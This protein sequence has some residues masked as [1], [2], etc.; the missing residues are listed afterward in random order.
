MADA[1]IEPSL[2]TERRSQIF[3]V[4]S[5]D[6]V[7]RMRSFG[8][9]RSWKDG[10]SLFEAGKPGP[11]MFVVLAGRVMVTRRDG[12][13]HDVTVIE[14]G[15]GEFLAEVGQLSGAPSFVDGRASGPVDA[16]LIPPDRLRA[17][18]V[19]EAELGERVMRALI[20]RRVSLLESHA[21]GPVL[22]ASPDAP[23]LVRLQ[24]FLTRNGYPHTVMN[25]A[26]PEAAAL[27]TCHAAAGKPTPLIL[28]PNGDVLFDPSEAELAG[29]LGMS[30]TWPSDAIFDVVVVGGGPAGLATAVYAASEALSVLVLERRAFGGQAGASAR[31]ENYLGFPTGIS[32]QALAGRA[33]VQAQKFGAVIAVPVVVSS[34]DCAHAKDGG[35][36]ELRTEDGR[37]ARGRAVIV[38][39]G[40]VYRRPRLPELARYE[41]RGVW[42]WAS[43]IEATLCGRQEVVLVGGGNSAGQAAVFL[44][45]TAAKVHV[46]VRG[47]GLAASMSSYL[48]DRIAAQRNIALHFETELVGLSGERALAGVRW[49]HLRSG[50][51]TTLATRNVFLFI[52]ADPTTEWLSRC[53]V[54]LDKAGF[55]RTG[56]DLAEASTDLYRDHAALETSVPGV[57]AIGDVRSRSTKR[58]AA[59]VGEG[60]AVVGQIHARRARLS[61]VSE[62]RAETGGT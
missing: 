37:I 33:F 20:L 49:R 21:G 34:L 28:L 16:L 26:E 36:F 43:P 50:E 53:G 10:E 38:A 54:E 35:P 44:A 5:A 45:Q 22:V 41:G 17:L 55:I 23:G 59:A 60:A 11:G 18:V 58:V 27:L 7:D 13:G 48:V 30:A 8:E 14:Q 12:L 52:G 25:P 40:V 47:P 3:P 24:G 15:P 57:F 32:G 29:R 6:E 2:H 46:L 4:L 31:I 62:P 42:Y 61:S 56:T 39:S 9:A 19:A 1:L 51:E